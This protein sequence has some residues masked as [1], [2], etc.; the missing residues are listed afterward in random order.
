MRELL[1]EVK[2]NTLKFVHI[3]LHTLLLLRYIEF[4]SEYKMKE[5]WN[6]VGMAAWLVILVITYLIWSTIYHFIF[7]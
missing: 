3:R 7:S 1:R 6:W 2:Y 4:K 5:K